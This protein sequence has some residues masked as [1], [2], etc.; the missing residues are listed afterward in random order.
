MMARPWL[1]EFRVSSGRV[2]R[3]LSFNSL[4]LR[5]FALILKSCFGNTILT[6]KSCL[7]F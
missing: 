6:L 3:V 1:S 5:E 4:S 2:V 7:N